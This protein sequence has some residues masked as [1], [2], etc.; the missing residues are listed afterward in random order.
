MA[1]NVIEVARCNT[2]LWIC[3]KCSECLGQNLTSGFSGCFLFF[4]FISRYRGLYV[5]LIEDSK[6]SIRV[7]ARLNACLSICAQKLAR[8][9][10]HLP[11]VSW[12]VCYF[13]F[14]KRMCTYLR[15]T[16]VPPFLFGSYN[17][18]QL[19]DEAIFKCYD[20]HI[21]WKHVPE[22]LSW[23]RQKRARCSNFAPQISSRHWR[24]KVFF[25]L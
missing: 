12:L 3:F 15:L 22:Q 14:T 17:A 21:C 23:S 10:M 8:H 24:M 11:P 2:F 18:V 1:L 20:F 6:L 7:N 4:M 16:Y 25:F 9:N 13:H 5:K 19:E